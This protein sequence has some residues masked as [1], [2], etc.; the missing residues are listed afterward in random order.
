[1]VGAVKVKC[2]HTRSEGWSPGK[3]R[4][5]DLNMVVVKIDGNYFAGRNKKYPDVYN[6]SCMGVVG[7]EQMDN[8]KAEKVKEYFEKLGRIVEIEEYDAHRYLVESLKKILAY[9][10]KQRGGADVGF[11][12]KNYAQKALMLAGELAEKDASTAQE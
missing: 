12:I 11:A 5:G 10:E 1:M 8:E 3:Y 6:I 7:A 4:K 9:D 2:V